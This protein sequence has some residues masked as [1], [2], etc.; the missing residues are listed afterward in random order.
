MRALGWETWLWRTLASVFMFPGGCLLQGEAILFFCPL[1]LPGS[2]PEGKA[3]SS[4][5]WEFKS[6]TL[7]N[8]LFFS[9]QTPTESK[10]EHRKRELFIF[11]HASVV[12]SRSWPS[13]EGQ[14]MER[15]GGGMGRGSHGDGEKQPIQERC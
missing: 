14:V 12:C 8:S 4:H 3:D 7:L 10:P 11:P 9:H 15:R 1:L 5:L 13:I 2:L 6:V